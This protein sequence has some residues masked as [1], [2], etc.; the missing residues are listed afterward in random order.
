MNRLESIQ[1]D[2]LQDSWVIMYTY[3]AKELID[4]G[5]FE[6]EVVLRE[7]IRRYGRDRGLVNRKRLLDNN[8]KIN[9]ITLFCEGRDRPGDSRFLSSRSYT[10][11]Q[12]YSSCIH[13]CSFADLWKHY[14]V[15]R[16][17]RIYCEEFH[18]A[19]YEAFSFGRMK[20]NLA[21]SLTQDG[22]DRCIFSHTLRPENMTSD[23]RKLCFPEFDPEYVRPEI[24]MP[25]P[26]GKSG[27]NMLWIKMYYHFLSCA[28]E[29]MGDL[30]RVFVGNGL[31]RAAKE[32]ANLLKIKSQATEQQLD[33]IYVNENLPLNIDIE[34]EPMWQS[35]D[36]F[37]AKQLL[38]D[39]F[40][41]PFWEEVAQ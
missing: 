38:I 31:R 32:Q 15:K 16:L 14:G 30:G 11:E 1:L 20:V 10:S 12:E 24:D 34:K 40:Y 27:F 26:I 7:A 23:E 39:C 18:I 17:G 6:G 8:I 28:T 5:G 9:L 21:R 35:Y 36:Q 19:C 2:N 37:G 33:E 3:I 4:S 25:K 41:K 29:Q 22:D 13:V